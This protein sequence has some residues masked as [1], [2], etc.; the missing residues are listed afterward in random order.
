MARMRAVC[1]LLALEADPS[2]D[3]THIRKLIRTLG[4]A[5]AP[6]ASR[7][8]TARKE[9]SLVKILASA[10][11]IAPHPAME[12][13]LLM[14]IALG[15]DD[16]PESGMADLHATLG[17]HLSLTEVAF[18]RS[19]LETGSLRACAAYLAEL[20]GADP[21]ASSFYE[22]ALGYGSSHDL[23]AE[24]IPCLVSL[25]TLVPASRAWAASAQESITRP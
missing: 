18:T 23:P 20:T 21:G 14:G 2:P 10:W 1:A 12:T 16:E 17:M 9:P 19:S 7:A 22:I 13:L 5:C 4:A 24:T 15:V 25:G 3:V 8:N 6:N 11:S